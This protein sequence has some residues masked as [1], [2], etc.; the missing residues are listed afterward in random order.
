[1]DVRV[2]TS[3]RFE[4]AFRRLKR[5]YPRIEAPF[6][7]LVDS[8][9]SGE[10]PGDKIPGVG[11]DVYKVRLK[12]PSARKGKRGGLRVVYYIQLADLVVLLTIYTK[13]EQSD[14]SAEQLRRIIEEYAA[15]QQGDE[16]AE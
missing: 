9:K 5:K 15:S 11:Y 13:S 4:A 3:P 10:R 14:I 7:D 2:L 12:N 1:M 6:G 16:R 8:L